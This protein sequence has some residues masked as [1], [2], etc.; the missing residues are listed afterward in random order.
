MIV[1]I[2]KNVTKRVFSKLFESAQS[3]FV[4]TLSASVFRPNALTPAYQRI[5]VTTPSSAS[6][7]F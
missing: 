4:W 3:I 6:K 5:H 1:S 7:C 2:S